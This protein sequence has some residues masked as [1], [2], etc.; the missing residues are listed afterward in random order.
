LAI[1]EI[2]N[3]TE[4][5]LKNQHNLWFASMRPDHRPHLVPVWFVWHDNKFYICVAPDSVKAKNIEHMPE[6]VLALEDGSHPVI[7]EGKAAA[8]NLPW[9]EA[10]CAIFK[11]KYDWEISTEKQ[12]TQLLEITPRKWLVW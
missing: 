4:S 5:K 9:P 3:Q 8:L 6:V 7:C 11:E 1:A 10:V 2:D 12:Y